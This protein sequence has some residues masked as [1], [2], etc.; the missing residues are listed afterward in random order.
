MV[1]ATIYPLA[2]YIYMYKCIWE[3]AAARAF[4]LSAGERDPTFGDPKAP[5]LG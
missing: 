4:F 3:S 5:A 1:K 2:K